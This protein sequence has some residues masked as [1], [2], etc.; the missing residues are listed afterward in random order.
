MW[1]IFYLKL[2]EYE[3]NI[4]ALL[5]YAG[6]SVEVVD[7]VGQ[8]RT[9]CEKVEAC[10]VQPIARTKLRISKLSKNID[11]MEIEFD[12]DDDSDE[13]DSRILDQIRANE[14]IHSLV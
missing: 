11:P 14:S 1:Y 13:L 5:E 7:G 8:I 9:V 2:Q 10:L 3:D 4:E 6:E 12:P